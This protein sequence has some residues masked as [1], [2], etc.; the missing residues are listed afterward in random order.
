MMAEKVNLESIGYL[1]KIDC[2]GRVTL[3]RRI[4]QTMKIIPGEYVEIFRTRDDALII[5]R[6]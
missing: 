4:K 1:A 6:T 2:A 5:K 3:P